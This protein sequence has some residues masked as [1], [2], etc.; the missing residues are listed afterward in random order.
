VLFRRE[1]FER[2]GGYREACDYWEDH[3]LFF[4]FAAVGRV[5]V[6]P[7]QLYRYRFS[8]VS[9]RTA[10]SQ[11]RM[12]AAMERMF[13]CV[14]AHA[15][16]RPYDAMLTEPSRPTAGAKL[17]LDVFVNIGTPRLWAGFRPG[18]LRSLLRRGAL[19][20]DR[21]S[22]TTVA[23]A[24][25][26]TLA[27]RPLRALLAARASLRDRWVGSRFPDGVP[28]EWSPLRPEH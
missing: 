23:W 11:E 9:C 17:P 5:M 28:Y 8:G 1:V 3:D 13:R 15:A 21:R 26:G 22:V 24:L 20:L 27:P 6:L 19:R 2:I 10:V 7:D 18:I 16:G 14:E 4:R 12:E 25:L